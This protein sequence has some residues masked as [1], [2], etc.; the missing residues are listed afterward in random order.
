MRT[1]DIDKLVASAFDNLV[2]EALTSETLSNV[3]LNGGE[4]EKEVEKIFHSVLS[5]QLSED[6]VRCQQKT[7]YD[8]KL[9]IHDIVVT[10]ENQRIAVIEIKSI[11]TDPGSISRFC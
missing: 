11:F 1:R 4:H 2:K 6:T 3:A 8:G 9:K 10:R 7:Y 5:S